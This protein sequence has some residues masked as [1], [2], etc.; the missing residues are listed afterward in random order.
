MRVFNISYSLYLQACIT[1][2]DQNQIIRLFALPTVEVGD[3][4]AV[5]V[6]ESEEGVAELLDFGGVEL[7]AVY[8]E[9]IEEGFGKCRGHVAAG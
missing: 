2:Y 3:G 6:D 7:F 1:S 5:E 9:V 8:G 4:V